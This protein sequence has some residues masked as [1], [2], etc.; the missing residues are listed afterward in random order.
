M[1]RLGDS[2]HEGGTLGLLVLGKGDSAHGEG[3]KRDAVL[4]L[5]DSEHEGG[6]LGLL[7]IEEAGSEHEGQKKAT[8]RVFSAG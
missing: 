2:E 1:L 4:R 8:L 3:G 6:T 7:V 5:G